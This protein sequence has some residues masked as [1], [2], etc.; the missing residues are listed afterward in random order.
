MQIE[1]IAVDVLRHLEDLG[2]RSAIVGGLA[3][4]VR[5]RPRTT[6]DVDFA[7][8]VAG[9]DE[10]EA[11]VFA[12][13]R[14][15]YELFDVLEQ[16]LMG[17]LA[18]ARLARADAAGTA[19]VDLLFASSGIEAE[20]VEAADVLEVLP[21]VEMPVAQRGHLLALKV[22]AYDERRRPQDRL[23]IMAMLA[24]A[25]PEDLR[26]AREAVAL[27]TSRGFHRD[28]DLRAELDGFARRADDL[29]GAESG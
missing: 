18:T 14:R 22:L 10:A 21:G 25:S 9:D 12:F 16:T 20:V 13:Q 2:Y 7:V 29:R 23:D 27:V 26:M 4:G 24:V 17:R 5:A 6:L 28:K 11:L 1:R 19:F 15:G 3:V 8:S